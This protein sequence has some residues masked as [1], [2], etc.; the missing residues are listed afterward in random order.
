VYRKGL[1]IDTARTVEVGNQES[2]IKNQEFLRIGQEA[3]SQAIQQAVPGN[4]VGDISHAM[5][6]VIES[7][8]YSV[9]KAFVG[10]GVGKNLHEPP[11]IP[12]YGRAGHG[13][14]LKKGQSLAIEVMY[15]R[16]GYGV[17][18][19]DDGWTTITMDGSTAAMFEDT[20]IVDSPPRVVTA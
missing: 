16:G 12:C 2:R 7:A 3:L 15:T 4:R 10:H 11:Q 13:P 20:V 19:L 6:T 5:Q 14:I 1:H 9:I 8:G 17:E 18:V